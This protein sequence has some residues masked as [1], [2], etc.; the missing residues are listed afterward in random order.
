MRLS[1]AEDPGPQGHLRVFT[2]RMWL[3]QEEDASTSGHFGAAGGGRRR[4]FPTASSRGGAVCVFILKNGRGPA[5]R[6][7]RGRGLTGTLAASGHLPLLYSVGVEVVTQP[8]RRLAKL[9]GEVNGRG[10]FWVGIF[11]SLFLYTPTN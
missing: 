11:A 1:L 4:P 6:G 2:A 5:G 3:R 7:R 10:I 8:L 9:G